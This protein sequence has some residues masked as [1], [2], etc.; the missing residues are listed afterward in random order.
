MKRNQLWI[1]NGTVV[2]PDG[3]ET[4]DVVVEEGRIA[5]IGRGEDVHEG[6]RIIDADGA[7]VLPGL[8]DI[9]CD[10]IEKETEPRPNTLFPMEMAFLQ[11]ERKLAGHGITTMY[12]SLSLGVGLSL[13][14]EHLVSEMIDTIKRISAQ[15]SMI[16]H[17]IHLRYEVSHLTGFPLAERLIREGKI[18]YLSLMDHAPGQG[19]YRRP[20]AFQRYVM[21]NQGVDAEECARIVAEL[22]ERRSQVDW[23]KLRA[24][25]AL[26]RAHGIAVASHDDDTPEQADRSIA[27]GATVSEFPLNLETAAYAAG[28]GM[29]ICVGA[30][31]I[32]RGGSH[33]NNLTALEAVRAGAADIVC[34]DYHPAS[35][36]QSLFEMHAKGIPLHQAVGMATL[37]PSTAL[38]RAGELGS[39]EPGKLADLLVV[40]QIGGVPVVTDTLVEGAVVWQARDYRA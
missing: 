40:R 26:A 3:I 15:R 12:H 31:N 38:G 39:I 28:R 16:R 32:V 36:L 19:Q 10:A 5:R 21:K 33:D 20:G 4:A 7:F 6:A 1:R 30:P 23:S 24:L 17:R 25:T 13:R 29:N 8:V 2:L 11:F 18:D 27:Y 22:Q 34:S 14:G 9:H 35:L 37:A